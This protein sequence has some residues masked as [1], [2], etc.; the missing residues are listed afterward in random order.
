MK[1]FAFNLDALR[2]FGPQLDLLNTLNGGV[3]QTAIRVRQ[4]RHEVVIDVAAPGLDPEAFDISLDDD[5]RLTIS[6][7]ASPIDPAT[8]NLPNDLRVPLLRQQFELPQQIDGSRIE[9]TYTG[10]RLRVTLPFR[11]RAEGRARRID[12]RPAD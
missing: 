6:S 9:A 3:A 2:G 12:V 7:A 1:S 8:P 10:T 11:P 4:R 5:Q